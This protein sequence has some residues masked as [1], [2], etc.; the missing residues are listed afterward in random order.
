[1]LYRVPENQGE[2][3]NEEADSVDS[4]ELVA[5]PAPPPSESEYSEEEGGVGDLSPDDQEGAGEEDPAPVVVLRQVSVS[6]GCGACGAAASVAVIGH[7]D[8]LHILET[9]LYSDR[10]TPLCSSC[11]DDLDPLNRFN[12]RE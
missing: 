1:M 6:T 9:L 10:I 7:S 5:Y 3:S 11:A 4:E 8:A 2:S 12:G